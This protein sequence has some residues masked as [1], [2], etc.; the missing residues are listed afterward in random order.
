MSRLIRCSRH[1]I[2]GWVRAEPNKHPLL[3]GASGGI[4]SFWDLLSIRAIA[5]LRNR[6]VPLNE[7]STGAQYLTTELK[8]TR[9]FAHKG[10]ATVGTGFFAELG[11]WVDVGRG[12]QQAFQTV[13]QQFLRPIT[14]DDSGMAAIWRPHKGTWINP[15]IQAGT[16]CVDGTRVPTKMLYDLHKSEFSLH[17][18]AGDYRLPVEQVQAAIE[19]ESSL[20]T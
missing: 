19:Y 5:E 12:G 16:P 3:P 20:A 14:F 11:D 2:A 7:I 8:T 1:Q 17:D 10:L 6:G 9:P 4:F 13:I 18:L 15:N